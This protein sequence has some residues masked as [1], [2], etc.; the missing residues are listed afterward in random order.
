MRHPCHFLSHRRWLICLAVLPIGAGF[1]NS[2]LD[3]FPFFWLPNEAS[4]MSTPDTEFYLFVGTYTSGGS[5]G[6]YVY[7]FNAE[8]G[9][10]TYANK[11]AGIQNPSYLCIEPRT[12]YL[13]A[14]NENS[15]S[16]GVS[17][18]SIDLKTGGLTFLNQQSTQGGAPC[19]VS[20]DRE[21]RWVFA[22]NYSGR[23]ACVFP[24]ESDGKLAPASDVV[25]HT[26]SGADPR[27]QEGP[28]PHA[29]VLDPA[30]RFVFVPDLGLDKI[31]I[32][33]FDRAQGKLVPNTP[34]FVQTEP[35]SGPRHFVFHPNGRWAYSIQELDNTINAYSY[36]STTG[37]LTKIQTVPA[38]PADFKGTSYCA[39]IHVSPDGKFLYGSNRGHNSIA[40]YQI[41]ANTGH[42]DYVGHESTQGKTPRNFALDPTGQFLL[43]ANQDSGT[44]ATF[45]RDAHTGRLEFTGTLT[46][47]PM[48][49]CLKFI[50]ASNEPA[51][52]AAKSLE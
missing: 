25:Q 46:E 33:Q 42:L 30:D 20:V 40:V 35:A 31:M 7:R 17:A 43:A 13:Y 23:N 38:L 15:R 8:T 28:H 37:A 12:K 2:T 48:P 22:A 16:G 1:V 27:R 49:V 5:E 50:P 39:D 44:V 36:D 3:G 52:S 34:P 24:V 18:F 45:R 32:Y 9:K 51:S 14:V 41:D 29:I 21:S 26:G 4:A 47:I 10:L 11:A 19:Y 6:I